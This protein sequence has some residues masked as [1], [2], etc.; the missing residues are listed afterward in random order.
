MKET[1]RK[2]ERERERKR[3]RKRERERERADREIE[4]GP[5]RDVAVKEICR[6]LI[7]KFH[8]MQARLYDPA[9]PGRHIMV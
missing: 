3:E 5:M 9:D 6:D 2:R 8:K 4:I 1:K 7:N